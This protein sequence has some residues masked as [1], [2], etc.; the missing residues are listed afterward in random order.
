MRSASRQALTQ[1]QGAG[2]CSPRAL[3]RP[4]GSS[5]ALG[6]AQGSPV[7]RARSRAGLLSG[8]P[9]A[10]AGAAK[11]RRCEGSA[12]ERSSVRA[13]ERPERRGCRGRERRRLR[14]V[15]PSGGRG[16]GARRARLLGAPLAG[17]AGAGG[18]EGRS[19]TAAAAERRGEVAA[20]GGGS[21]VVRR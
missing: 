11:R 1:R 10:A 4:S 8:G 18:G 9:V 14:G 19:G 3:R 5:R 7:V 2:A 15:R 13:Q 6:L 16:A 21:E 20:A 12:W 17:G